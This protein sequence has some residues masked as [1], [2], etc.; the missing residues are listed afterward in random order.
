M[1][2][3]LRYVGIAICGI[4][5]F[6]CLSGC[7]FIRSAINDFTGSLVGNSYHIYTYDNYGELTMETSGDKI[8]ISGNTVKSI[9]YDSDGS[10]VTNYDLSSVITITIDGYEIESCGDT[11]IFV[12]DGLNA[13]V[14]FAEEVIESGTDGGLTDNASIARF[15]NRYKNAFGKSR[16]VVIKSQLGQPIAAYSGDDVYWE[17]PDDI[18][19]CTKLMI[20]GKALYIHRA[21]FQIID[22]ALIE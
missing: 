15:L 8:S 17:I 18:P 21:N 3:F 6:V 1:R 12:Q 22:K 20:D 2:K 4:F 13:E 7:A 5:L 14:D 10:T 16:I 11:C 9:G 19:K